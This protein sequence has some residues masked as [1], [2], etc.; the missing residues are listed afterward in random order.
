M[1]CCSVGEKG[2]TETMTQQPSIG[3]LFVPKRSAQWGIFVVLSRGVWQAL[4][5]PSMTT[6]GTELDLD[7]VDMQHV[8]PVKGPP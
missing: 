1:P 7:P 2:Q 4:K 8:L 6:A 5:R 3:V